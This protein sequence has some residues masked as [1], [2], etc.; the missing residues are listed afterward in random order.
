MYT[1]GKGL[2]KQVVSGTLRDNGSAK[3]PEIMEK[4]NRNFFS[5]SKTPGPY[6]RQLRASEQFAD[7]LVFS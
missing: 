3:G 2:V 7:V 6:F 5:P 1:R 4:L